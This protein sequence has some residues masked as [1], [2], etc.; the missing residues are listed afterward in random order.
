MLYKTQFYFSYIRSLSLRRNTYNHYPE[1]LKIFQAK[2]GLSKDA[3]RVFRAHK[4]EMFYIVY[5]H[6]TRQENVKFANG[7][8]NYF[9]FTTCKCNLGHLS[10]LIRRRNFRITVIKQISTTKKSNNNIIFDE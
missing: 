9:N 1:C 3:T 7:C 10:N 6:I 8:Y 4:F 2:H 5:T